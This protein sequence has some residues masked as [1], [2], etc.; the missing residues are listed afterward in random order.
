MWSRELLKSNAKQCLSRT[1]KVS[2]L[3]I[4]ANMVIGQGITFTFTY[5]NAGSASLS[6]NFWSI[7]SGS[8]LVNV[9]VTIFLI[10]PLRV[11]MFR[12]FMEAR[13][14]DAPFGSLFGAFH[15]GDYGNITLG[16][17]LTHLKIALFSLL[18]VI[19]GIIKGYE[20]FLVPFL[21][22]ENPQM[23]YQRAQ[24]LSRDI[25]RGEKWNLFVL[26][27][28]FFGWILLSSILIAIL[29][30]LLSILVFPITFVIGALLSA[31]M[32]ATFA[33]FYAAMREKAF[34]QNLSTPDEL[35][36]F[37]AY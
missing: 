33:E 11:G 1:W 4:A 34:A 2:L 28:S 3:V 29:G 18:L 7:F 31:Y 37:I 36:G 25:M 20:Y 13:Q 26:E 15:K 27:F 9:L 17:F 32:S 35:G 22:A 30:A 21:L 8:A 12:Y 19:P 14:G 16:L 6:P 10:S 5:F 23:N 24:Q